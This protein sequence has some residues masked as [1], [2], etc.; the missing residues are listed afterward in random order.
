MNDFQFMDSKKG[1]KLFWYYIAGATAT[2]AAG[3]F[4]SHVFTYAYY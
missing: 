2:V 1:L 4:Y 3:A